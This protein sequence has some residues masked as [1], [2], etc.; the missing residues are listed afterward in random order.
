MEI[1]QEKF[2]EIPKNK[3][4]DGIDMLKININ[5]FLDSA[6][7]QIIHDKL[8][9]ANILTEFSIEELGKI[10]MLKDEYEKQKSD[11]VKLPRHILKSH[12]GKSERAWQYL[13][14][15]FK[16]ISQGGF[17]RNE[18]GTI[19][20]ERGFEQVTFSSHTTRLEC[21]FVDFESSKNWFIG[22]NI[23][24]EKLKNQVEHIREKTKE[25][26]L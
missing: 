21:A 14:Q 22:R 23:D 3:F 6:E 26:S 18:K 2:V 20:F 19:G 11:P 9:Q 13:D 1:L 15:Q 17:E 5:N 24:K 7:I 4:Q 8:N 25:I 16:M 12:K 10:L